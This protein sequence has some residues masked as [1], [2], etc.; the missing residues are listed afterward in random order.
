MHIIWLTS[1]FPIKDKNRN[2]L[3]IYRTVRALAEK[4]SIS[5]IV[6]HPVIPPIIPMLKNFKNWKSVY[7]E[8]KDRFPSNPQKPKKMDGIDVH[9]AKFIRPPRIGNQ[10]YEGWFAYFAIK[11]L[12]LKHYQS[13]Y[14]IH[15]NW[16]FPEGMAAYLLCKKLNI[17][18]LI[19]LRGHDINDLKGKTKD[20]FYAQK[21]FTKADMVT[22]VSAS[23]FDA[24]K[25]KGFEIPESKTSVTHNFYDFESFSIKSKNNLR[26][27]LNIDPNEYIILAAGNLNPRKNFDLLIRAI[28]KL[29][30]KN[31]TAHLLI[32]GIGTEYYKLDSLSTELGVETEVQFLGDLNTELIVNYYNVANLFC[33]PS[34]HEG[35]ANV[36]V[37]SMLCGTPVLVSAVNEAPRIIN[38]AKNGY[39]VV[40]NSL[41]SLV[42]GINK[43]MKT[44][45]DSSTIRASVNYLSKENILNAFDLVYNRFNS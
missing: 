7:D 34:K 15:A 26:Q 9:Y 37:E 19:T 45:W 1:Q 44:D 38:E 16:L 14:I 12:L 28:S 40:P 36:I 6:L 2:G 25:E 5:V 8:W 32:A 42:N 22:T 3:F 23:L 33:L 24:C 30:K 4:R 10:F 39:L 27:A 43:C 20:W 18:F 41:E 31:I 17:P 13:G 35:L 21:I 11:K 29:K